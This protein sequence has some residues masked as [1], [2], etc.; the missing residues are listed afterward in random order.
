MRFFFKVM[1]VLALAGCTTSTTPTTPSTPVSSSSPAASSTPAAATGNHEFAFDSPGGWVADPKTMEGRPDLYAI[2][3]SDGKGKAFGM[4][5]DFAY[6]ASDSTGALGEELPPRLAAFLTAF[7]ES[8]VKRYDGWK[9]VR[10]GGLEFNGQRVAELVFT[11]EDTTKVGE[12]QQWR[13]IL[14]MVSPTV[15]NRLILLGFGAPMGKEGDYQEDFQAI[16]K[17]WRWK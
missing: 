1:I 15:E 11:G 6:K 7:E 12:G 4:R 2:Q 9:L 10:H 16:E 5:F 3:S 8:L 17:S 13:R 14:V